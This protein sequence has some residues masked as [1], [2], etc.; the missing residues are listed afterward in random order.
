MA[1]TRSFVRSAFKAEADPGLALA[2]VSDEL[3]EGNESCMFV[4]LFC[5]RIDL[6]VGRVT[7]ANAGHNAPLVVRADG[8]LEWIDK[9]HGTAAGILPGARYETGHL[10]LD[11]DDT[12]LLYT[13]GVT[14][15]MDPEHRQYGEA[16][17]TARMAGSRTLDCRGRLTALAADVRAHAA[18]AEQSD[19]I[20]MLMLRRF[21]GTEPVA[22]SDEAGRLHL[23]I[24]NRPEGLAAAL[25]R[26]ETWL[27]TA[28]I[29]QAV[30]YVARLVLEE[31]VTNTIKYG[32]PNGGAHC[33]HVVVSRGPPATMTIEDD[34][35]PF[36]LLLDAP[37][38]DLDAGAAERPIGQGNRIR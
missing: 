15:A 9:P 14:E 13:D 30:H 20:T 5:A 21:A 2:R 33:I 37:L 23:D 7:Y 25:G 11:S 31:L 16:R 17:L 22:Q 38:P 1:V 34:G 6:A 3:S 35:Q 29:P 8:R 18:G 4:T 10:H 32:Y 36:N 28:D 24:A 26:L 12:L 27:G 19:D